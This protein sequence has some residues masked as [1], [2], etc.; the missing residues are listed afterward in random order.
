MAIDTQTIVE[1]VI[2]AGGGSTAVSRVVG[3]TRQAVEDWCRIPAQHVL[4]LEE[5]TGISRHAMRPDVFGARPSK[6][7]EVA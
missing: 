1:R 5:L 3:V 4:A 6:P 7:R 2:R